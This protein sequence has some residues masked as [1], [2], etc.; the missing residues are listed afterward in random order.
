MLT[1]QFDPHA[2]FAF[3]LN[4]CIVYSSQFLFTGADLRRGNSLG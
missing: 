3:H 4:D 2:N 1:I